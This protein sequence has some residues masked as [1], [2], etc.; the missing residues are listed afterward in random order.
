M[1]STRN[2]AHSVRAKASAKVIF[3]ALITPSLIK[4]WWYVHTAIVIPEVGGVYALAWGDSIDYPD[5]VTVSRLNEYEF[6][7]KISMK[8]ESYFS[9][10]G[11]L[12]F[13]AE[14]VATI[15]LE[16]D[17][18]ETIIKVLQT[19]IPADS[20]ADDFYEGT[21][22]GWETTLLSLKNLAEDEA[23][24]TANLDSED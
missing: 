21:V 1:G 3:N 5:Y 13:E 7:K 14:L 12:P 8:N 4:Q 22:K 17:G 15:S 19:G 24:S 9:P 2:I 16:E 18:E 6:G 20:V 23:L 11:N 10:H